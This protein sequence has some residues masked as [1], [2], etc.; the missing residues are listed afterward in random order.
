M[1]QD[2]ESDYNSVLAGAEG[3]NRIT[4]IES[5]KHAQEE[6][7]MKLQIYKQVINIV[8]IVGAQVRLHNI[9][10]SFQA[11]HESSFSS[12]AY[13]RGLVYIGKTSVMFRT[14]HGREDKSTICWCP[15]N[16]VGVC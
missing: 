5:Q 10:V 13:S 14:L 6:E 9:T 15:K 3:D 7:H 12:G 8:S 1:R 4:P 11:G 16:I 2:W